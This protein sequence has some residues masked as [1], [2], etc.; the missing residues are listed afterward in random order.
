MHT[1]NG[2]CRGVH[3]KSCKKNTGGG[4]RAVLTPALC[5]YVN[6]YHY[7]FRMR[8]NPQYRRRRLERQPLLVQRQQRRRRQLLTGGGLPTTANVEAAANDETINP[9]G[10][11][12]H[13]R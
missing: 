3:R 10:T 7:S 9:T 5:A 1:I 13:D 6:H 11:A 8:G 2:L 4:N 12:V